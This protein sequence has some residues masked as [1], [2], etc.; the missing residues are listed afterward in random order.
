MAIA[1]PPRQRYSSG[2]TFETE[3]A[4]SRVVVDG[5]WIFVA[6][7]TG[8]NYTTM[9][10]PE[11]PA[12]QA[13]QCFENV[14]EALAQAGAALED[15]VRV[16]YLVTSRDDV[17]AFGPVFR[18]YFGDILPAATMHVVGLLNEDMKIEIE[19]TAR[20]GQL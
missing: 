10:L 1:N 8:Y 14:K 13:A 18:R 9:T 16:T 17:P 20:R 19:V 4:Y 12:E 3:F 15:V 2:S 6:G 5:D 7:T 11:T